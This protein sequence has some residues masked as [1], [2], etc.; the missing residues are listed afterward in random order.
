MS[1]SDS[2]LRKYLELN[3]CA[4]EVKGKL[5]CHALTEVHHLDELRDESIGPR[6]GP[7]EYLHARHTI[8]LFQSSSFPGKPTPSGSS[9]M[10]RKG[11]GEYNLVMGITAWEYCWISQPNVPSRAYIQYVDT[12]G[13]Y[14]PRRRQGAM[15]RQVISVYLR[16]C[17]EILK[18]TSVHLFA[19][20][21]PSLLFGGSECMARKKV[22]DGGTLVNWWLALVHSAL[23]SANEVPYFVAKRHFG[24]FVYCAAADWMPN[25]VQILKNNVGILN[26]RGDGATWAYGFP[27]DNRDDACGI[28]LFED[29][30]KWRHYEAACAYTDDEQKSA[31]RQRRESTTVQTVEEFFHSLSCRSEFRQEPCA[32]ISATFPENDSGTSPYSAVRRDDLASLTCKIL[33]TL[34]FETEPAAVKSS[35]RLW[36]WLKLM[37]VLPFE[38]RPTE[39]MTIY[40]C[41]DQGLFGSILDNLTKIDCTINL[42]SGTPHVH[43]DVQGLVRKKR[44]QA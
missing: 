44:G 20:T 22:L 23:A 7:R 30:P 27:Y 14:R 35:M 25:V 32:F 41:N 18:V 13:F 39:E 12:T 24:G 1:S 34:T 33:K 2:P 8:L 6:R 15:T 16:Y 31:K 9:P 40:D 3:L 28:P 26:R 19:S 17:R 38:V 29:D 36:A 11:T 10:K 4:G 43:N 37:G 21:K 42:P 5:Y